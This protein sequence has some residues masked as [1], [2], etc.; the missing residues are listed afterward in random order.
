MNLIHKILPSWNRIV[1]YHRNLQKPQYYRRL[2]REALEIQREEI[3]GT[4]KKTINQ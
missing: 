3:N 1:K 2:I 4:E